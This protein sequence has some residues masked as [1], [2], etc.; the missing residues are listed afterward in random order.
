MRLMKEE[1]GSVGVQLCVKG[2]NQQ[3]N[4]LCVY[5]EMAMFSLKSLL[6]PYVWRLL[7]L[8]VC[9]TKPLRV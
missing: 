4:P 2:V 8:P 1:C 5:K 9:S 6:S 7:G 3:E